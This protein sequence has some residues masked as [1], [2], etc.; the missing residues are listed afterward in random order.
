MKSLGL[1]VLFWTIC[2]AVIAQKIPYTQGDKAFSLGVNNIFIYTGNLFSTHFNSLNI[3]IADNY[4]YRRFTSN[5][6][7][8]RYELNGFINSTQRQ[9]DNFTS[10]ANNYNVSLLYGKEKHWL[11]NEINVYRYYGFGG[12]FQYI[13][14]YV[15]NILSDQSINTFN[16]I[17]GPTLFIPFKLGV[18]LEY[19]FARYFFIGAEGGLT[20]NVSHTFRNYIESWNSDTPHIKEI[21]ESKN[22]WEAHLQFI[23]SIIFR[24]GFKF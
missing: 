8:H 2:S 20:A 24:A 5:T 16:Q 9:S 6:T 17:I 10:R 13:N 21:S 12:G 14:N 7:A 3:P 11:F 1:G 23:N 18:G 19:H 15:E 22:L 4:V